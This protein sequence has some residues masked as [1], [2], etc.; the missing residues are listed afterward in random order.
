MERGSEKSVG[1]VKLGTVIHAGGSGLV[2][3]LSQCATNQRCAVI[4]AHVR[5]VNI[6]P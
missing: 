1:L 2:D 6:L 5:W 3:A 4:I